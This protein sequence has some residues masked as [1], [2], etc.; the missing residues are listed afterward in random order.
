SATR[1]ACRTPTE[2]RWRPRLGI[3][4]Y[5]RIAI[6]ALKGGPPVVKLSQNN[7]PESLRGG[8]VKADTKK[9]KQA[10]AP[11]KTDTRCS[12][13]LR[14][15]LFRRGEGYSARRCEDRGRQA[16]RAAYR[17]AGLGRRGA[18]GLCRPRARQLFGLPR[19]FGDE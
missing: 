2:R 8:P 17:H 1:P 11:C 7:R 10:H 5:A 16:R 9:R 19:Q 4:T 13:I 15:R 3:E 12:G 6:Y 14:R 18:Q